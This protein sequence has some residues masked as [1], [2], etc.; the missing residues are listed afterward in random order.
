MQTDHFK[1]FGAAVS[2]I[3]AEELGIDLYSVEKV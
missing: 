1:E 2:N 3:L